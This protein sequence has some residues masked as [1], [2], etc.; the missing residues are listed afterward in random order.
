MIHL[1]TVSPLTGWKFIGSNSFKFDQNPYLVKRQYVE[2]II[3]TMYG[4]QEILACICPF[5]QLKLVLG[6]HSKVDKKMPVLIILYYVKVEKQN[7]TLCVC[8]YI[9]FFQMNI[10]FFYHKQKLSV[11][12]LLELVPLS[13]GKEDFKTRC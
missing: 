11:S 3:S 1:Q 6:L 9:V 13:N 8:M 5:I 2:G 10:F 4:L 12:I 7:D